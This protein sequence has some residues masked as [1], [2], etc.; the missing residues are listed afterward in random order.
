MGMRKQLDVSKLLLM[1]PTHNRLN[2]QITLSWIPW[3]WRKRVV[4]VCSAGQSEEH[5]AKY[6]KIR[7]IEAPPSV[8]SI[9][10]KRKWMIEWAHRKGYERILMFDDDLR[11]ARREF[12]NDEGPPYTFKLVKATPQDVDWAFQKV[13]KMLGKF[14]HVGIAPRQGN[15]GLRGY[16]RW[17]PNYR[18]IYAL[19]YHVPTLIKNV[20]LGR[21]EHR[22]DMDMCLQLLTKGYPNRVLIEVVVDQSYN[23]PGGAKD[24]RTV[25][26]SNKDAEK[27]AKWFPDFVKVQERDY[28]RSIKRKEVVVAW[29]KAAAHGIQ[30]RDARRT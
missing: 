29:K 13:E 26:A 6:K 28:K 17:N 25:E 23:G 22:E 2:R 18:M 9:A 16:R 10:Q 15:N 5:A 1:I 27:L 11:F 4:M 12:T 21:I 30:R 14:A 24:E 19:G 8:K 7:V 20:K 3:M